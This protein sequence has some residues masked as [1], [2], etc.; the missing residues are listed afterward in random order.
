[1]AEIVESLTVDRVELCTREFAR[2][3]PKTSPPNTQVRWIIDDQEV[4][5][6]SNLL[7]VGPVIHG[8]M[9][10][11]GQT[12]KIQA[13]LDNTSDPVTVT[14][15]IAD[16]DIELDPEPEEIAPYPNKAYVITAEPRMPV[17]KARA[18]GKGGAISGLE[19]SVSVS[20]DPT[21]IFE[22]CVPNA[23]HNLIDKFDFSPANNT[24]QID[25]DF[26]EMIRGGSFGVGGKGVV[27]GCNVGGG[28][29]GR[30]LGTNPLRSD[31]QET[32]I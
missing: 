22:L 5:H 18:I 30:I 21:L 12:L 1:M 17:I 24:E 25:I 4:Y 10:S 19:W 11:Q 29:G 15:K 9:I 20:T 14:R 23:P 31:I 28:G 3:W 26:N 2:V 13:R 7:V 8:I 6:P 32:R 16:I 27:N